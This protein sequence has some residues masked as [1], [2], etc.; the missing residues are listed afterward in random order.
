MSR[1]TKVSLYP[2]SE[3]RILNFGAVRLLND[4]VSGE[5]RHSPERCRECK[6]ALGRLVTRL[7]EAPSGDSGDEVDQSGG[8]DEEKSASSPPDDWPFGG[9]RG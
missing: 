5:N 4:H 9:S 8:A 6:A 2:A 1:Q 7:P 3:H